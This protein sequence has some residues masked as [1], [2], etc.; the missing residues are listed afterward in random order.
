MTFPQNHAGL[1]HCKGE[2]YEYYG[3]VEHVKVRFS[4]P[5]SGARGVVSNFA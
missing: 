2:Y 5:G 1:I 4:E 3:R